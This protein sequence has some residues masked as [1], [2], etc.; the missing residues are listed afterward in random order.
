MFNRL[1]IRYKVLTVV[2]VMLVF[3]IAASSISVY[4]I[5]RI[6]GELDQIA[7]HLVPVTEKLTQ[8]DVHTLEQELHLERVFTYL[9]MEHA[10]EEK[11]KEEIAL[12]EKRGHQVDKEI[13][14]AK[15]L[16]KEGLHHSTSF[17]DINE[18]SRLEPLL[19]ILE[20]EHETLSRHGIAIIEA[21]KHGHSEQAHLLEGWLMESEENFDAQLLAHLEELE[22]F[23]ERSALNAEEHEKFL[24]ILNWSTTGLAIVIGLMFSGIISSEM[25]RPLKALVDATAKVEKGDLDAD[26]AVKAKDEIGMMAEQFNRMVDGIRKKERIKATFGQ[27]VDPR[28]VSSIINS[29]DLGTAHREP[30]TVFFSDIAG[31]SRVS[32]QF[33]PAAMVNLINE[34]LS[35]VSEPIAQRHGVI[36]KYIGDAVVAFWAPPF[37]TPEEGAVQSCHAALEQQYKI[38]TLRNMLPQILGI[39]KGLPEI[40]VRMGIATGKCVAGNIGGA[41]SK[42]FTVIGPATEWAETLETLNKIYQTNILVFETTVELAKGK[43]EFRRVDRVEI[44]TGTELNVYELLGPAGAVPLEIMEYKDAYEHALDALQMGDV[45]EAAKRFQACKEKNP[46]DGAVDHHLR[47]LGADK[48]QQTV[49]LGRSS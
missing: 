8:I 28:V 11:I 22:R 30:V 31:F 18:F 12:F 2:G 39:R 5:S 48:P 23:M 24:L 7:F 42:S 46:D 35:L 33:T 19:D 25:V 26:I 27:F 47:A 45:E 14:E 16:A 15:E 32:E 38:E 4:Y 20:T 29:Y 37:V 34:Y 1:P 21:L 40:N 44:G 41:H 9:E 10:P 17:S 6:K 36:D 49:F 43:M 13:A 3:M